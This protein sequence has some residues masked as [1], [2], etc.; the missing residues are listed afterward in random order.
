MATKEILLLKPV[1]NLGGE[2]DQVKVKAGYARNYLLP[3]KL[4]LPITQ[5]N[6]KYVESLK[7][8]RSM[9]EAK[10]LD[11]AQELKGRIEK[12]NL[13]FTVKTG[14]EGRMFGAVTAGDLLARIAAEGIE[15]DKKQVSLYTPVKSLGKHSTKIRLHPDVSFDFEFEVVSEDQPVAAE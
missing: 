1:D 11:K 12:L 13:V 9:R 14:E 10:E 15:L 5:A 8:A 4:A 6:R 3:Q 2:G 7:K